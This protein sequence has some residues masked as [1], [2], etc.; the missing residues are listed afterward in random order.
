MLKK[1][2]PLTHRISRLDTPTL[3]AGIPAAEIV[4]PDNNGHNGRH[5]EYSGQVVVRLSRELKLPS[6]KCGGLETAAKELNLDGLKRVLDEYDLP[7]RRVVRSMKQE[8]ILKL[9]REAEQTELPPLHSLTQY[10]KIDAR[11]KM[12]AIP[13]LMKLLHSLKEVEY[14]YAELAAT[15]PVVNAGNDPYNGTQNYLDAAPTGID[16]RWA[17]TQANGEGAGIGFVDLEQG[18]FLT[19]ED[20]TGKSPSLLSGDNRDGVGTYKGNHGTAVL[21][22]VIADDNTEGVVGIAPSLASANVTSHYDSGSGT[23]GN[24]ADAIMGALPSMNPGDV[25]LL[26]IQKSLKPT[27]IDDADFD[28]IRLAVA[29]GVVVVEAAGNGGVNL[30]TYTNGA[31]DFILNR[32]HADF[33]ESGAIM[34]GAGSSTV[35]HNRMGFSNFGTRIDCYAWGEN[36]TTCG[37]G[38]L[39]A[40]TGDTSTY[41]D[42]FNGTSSASPIVSGAAVIVQGMYEANTGARLSPLQMRGVLSN[43]ATGTAPGGGVAGN[44]GVMPDLRAI[45]QNTLGIVPDI[46]M[47]DNL[48]D[49]G[50]TPTGGSISGSPDIIARKVAVADPNAAFGQGSGTENS[51]TLGYE[52]EAGQDNFIYARMKNRGGSNANNVTAT[53]YWSEVSTLVTPDMW[54]LI[55]T[56]APVNVPMGDTLVVADPLTW[57]SGD[58]PATGHYCFVGILGHPGDPAPPL[59]GP[60]DWD[61]FRHFITDNNN[62][63]WRNFNVIDA[64]PDAPD[65]AV[66]P[67]LIAGAPDRPRRFDLELHLHFAEGARAMLEVPMELGKAFLEGRR[68]K[69]EVDRKK[70]V[71]RLHLPTVPRLFVPGVYLGKS[72]RHKCRFVIEGVKKAVQKGNRV[73]I[74]QLFEQQEVGR[75]TWVFHDHKDE[76]C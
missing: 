49:T 6:E 58:I 61:G 50:N 69:Y 75:V 32:G 41:T 9:E 16:A 65:P 68:W 20:Y 55:G 22:E 33:R 10:W 72:A 45:I 25:L 76:E 4:P 66:L 51:N 62:V 12:D 34:C 59:P 56:T 40:G 19:H 28:A 7:T 42:S 53:V 23:T 14:V 13:E 2:L 15:D 26:E 73:A 11:E 1:R 17:W 29:H 36:V 47:R 37:Y 3:S 63:V 5:E 48:A 44:I 74:R 39:D 24:V 18:W 31:G 43:P 30:D 70:Q 57:S 35:P 46:Y 71:I 52:I 67:F 64:D 54:N 8:E 27:E 38:D 60:T 21:G